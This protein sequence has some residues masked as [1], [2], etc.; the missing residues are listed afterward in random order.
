MERWS[1]YMN[2]CPECLHDYSCDGFIYC[3]MCGKL[4]EHSHPSDT[5]ADCPKCGGAG[6]GNE[7]DD[8]SEDTIAD[9][10]TRYSCDTCRG[11]L[12]IGNVLEI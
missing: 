5:A 4:L 8:A 12:K 9:A 3:P 1:E 7:L 10:M 2:K 6:W 11:K